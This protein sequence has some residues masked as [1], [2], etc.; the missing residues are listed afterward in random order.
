AFL[1]CW[2][3]IPNFGTPLYY[4]LT[5]RL[6][7]DQYFIG[8][9]VSL[10]A[11]GAT[12][13]AI[14]YRRYGAERLS[15]PQW[16]YVS[17]LSSAATAFAHLFLADAPSAIAVYV[18]GGGVSMV[19]LLTIFSVAASVCPPQAAGSTFAALMAVYSAAA[20][21]SSMLG[22]YLYERVFD[23]HIAPL[24]ALAGCCTLAVSFWVPFLPADDGVTAELANEN[25]YVG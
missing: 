23:H 4:H 11:V 2:N 5:D 3:L 22:G 13:G 7:F 21:V 18:V 9:L 14:A 15:T 6:N 24:I 25:A 17:I 16:L 20:Q 1:A 10:G 19:A 8:Q 12:L